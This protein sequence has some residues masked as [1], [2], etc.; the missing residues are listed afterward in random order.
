MIFGYFGNI[1]IVIILQI[2][3]LRKTTVPPCAGCVDSIPPGVTDRLGN[4][5]NYYTIYPSSCG[6]LDDFD[7]NS[8]QMCCACKARMLYDINIYS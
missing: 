2:Y 1:V 6:D 5:C 8:K 3:E 4:D 7:F